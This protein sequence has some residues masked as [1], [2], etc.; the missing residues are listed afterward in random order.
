MR[1]PRGIRALFKAE[2]GTILAIWGVSLTAFLGLVAMSFDL[3][4]INITQTEMQSYVDHVA[5]AAAGELDGELDSITR[6]TLAA[7]TLVSDYQTFAAGGQ[8]LGPTD[9]TLTFFSE[10][11]EADT[12]TMTGATTN[13]RDAA[14]VRVKAVTKT[15][16]LTFGAAFVALSGT[17]GP[18]NT[19]TATAVA[20]FTQFAC[21]VTPLMFCLPSAG[22]DAD[23]NIGDMLHLRSG[24]QG[25]AW[26]PGDFGFLDP[27]K[28]KVDDGGPCDGLSGVQLD[29]CLMG[30]VGS[31]TQCF[32][33]RG[34]D[35]EPGQ[36]VGN[37][38]AAIN[39]RFDIYRAV[40]NNKRNDPDYAPAPNVIKGIKPDTGG[41]N[42]GNAGGGNQCI[43][44]N[45][46]TTNDTVGLPRDTCIINGSCGRI[47][48]GAW[49]RTEYVDR[50]YG[51]ANGILEAGEDPH[52]NAG[53][54]YE[55]YLAE[56][57]A[58]GANAPILTG[59]EETGRPMCSVN[60]TNDPERRVVIA[61]GIDCNA[62]PISGAQQDVPVREFF[63]IFLTEPAGTDGATPP[64][65]EIFGEVA[66]SAGGTG[67]GGIAG[68]T[69]HDVV[70]LYR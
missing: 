21:D 38:E 67:G 6:A 61:A 63:K 29:T 1:K 43:G 12:D 5:L 70:Q 50:N 19:I 54:R 23:S 57:A 16:D 28:I 58:A 8:A 11:P 17:D 7:N 13:P 64:N 32:S 62:N 52:P 9:F 47:G 45:E 44:G 37:F 14:Y 53:T 4:R 39:V 49:D 48:N 59:R 42:G 3:G 46:T 55:Y 69:F 51:N 31:I 68:A 34:V 15:V 36:K 25:S 18:D 20:G 30:A 22:Y 56:I 26:G 27:A 10:L 2:G 66:G 33:M 35:I 24:G 60:Q 40:V 65:F 41:G